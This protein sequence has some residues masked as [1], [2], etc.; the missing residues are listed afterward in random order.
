MCKEW[1]GFEEFELYTV[2]LTRSPSVI[3]IVGSFVFT[4]EIGIELF[5]VAIK[6]NCLY[7]VPSLRVVTCPQLKYVK[8]SITISPSLDGISVLIIID[9]L[10]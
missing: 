2:I 10:V 9:L 5:S 4:S 7:V 6:A 1:G 3:L 8:Y